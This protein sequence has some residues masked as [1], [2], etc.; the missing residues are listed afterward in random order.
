MKKEAKKQKANYMLQ[1]K[2]QHEEPISKK[3]CHGIMKI[4]HKDARKRDRDNYNKL[5]MD[6]LEGTV[7]KDDVQIHSMMVEKYIDR[8]NPRIEIYLRFDEE[9]GVK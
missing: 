6:A 8:E 4:Y 3:I 9:D 2:L 1:I 5:A 7:I